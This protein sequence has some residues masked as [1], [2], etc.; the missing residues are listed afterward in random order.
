MER[1]RN[2]EFRRIFK[3]AFDRLFKV[4]LGKCQ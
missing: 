2:S 3:V 1:K 4:R